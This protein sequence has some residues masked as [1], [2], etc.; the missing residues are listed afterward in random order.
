MH[1]TRR[2]T[3][4]LLFYLKKNSPKKNGKVTIMARITVNGKVAQ[5]STKLDTFIEKW[6]LKHNR[7]LGRSKEANDINNRLDSI[8]MK[9]TSLY[10]QF[11]E[12]DNHITA[13]SL[14]NEFLG[15][16]K[17]R[18][19]L[20]GLFKQKNEAFK[21]LIGVTRTRGTL[22]NYLNS[23]KHLQAFIQF[24]FHK[25]DVDL[26]EIDEDFIF[27]FDYYLRT[28]KN[29]K[30]N[31]VCLYTTP[32]RSVIKLAIQ[33]DIIQKNPCIHYKI[34]MKETHRVFLIKEDIVKLNNVELRSKSD[35]IRDM[36]LF[37][38]FT[39]LSH[40]DLKQLKKE[41]IQYST[42]G[43]L[44]L[45]KR[46]RKTSVTSTVK[47]LDIPKKIILKYRGVS[48]TDFVFSMPET[49]VCNYHLKLISKKAEIGKHIS[50][51]TARHTF[52]TLFLSEGVSIESIS[53][54][55][56]HKD[57]KTTQIYA[58]IINEKISKEIDEFVLK[59]SPFEQGLLERFQ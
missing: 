17:K 24:E 30:D 19:S 6:N 38:C 36:F 51:H 31:S 1:K 41:D 13:Q 5:F 22:S 20:I 11:F 2:S 34:R 58:K 23:L 8:R 49:G 46:R 45:I 32:V 35:F 54:M 53:K 25:N 43:S 33:K 14:K 56:G 16:G 48:G 15:I 7:I 55:M 42:D 59:I 44:W 57:I 50:F 10:N 27:K 28:V 29:L 40:I 12:K 9:I 52:A 39:G 18:H 3:F 26:Q 47:L 4:K 37:S 21:K